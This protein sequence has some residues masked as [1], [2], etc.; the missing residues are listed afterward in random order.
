MNFVLSVINVDDV[1]PFKCDIGQ[2]NH[3]ALR[4][5]QLA[6]KSRIDAFKLARKNNY[7]IKDE[8]LFKQKIIVVRN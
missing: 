6:D 4:E 5:E 3:V 1:L 7:I 2:S 8:L